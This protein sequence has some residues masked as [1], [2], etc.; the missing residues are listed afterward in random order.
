MSGGC[1]IVHIKLP[2]EEGG[3]PVGLVGTNGRGSKG[4]KPRTRLL[5]PKA[6]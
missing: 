4:C 3:L 2:V 1:P 5:E 6:G